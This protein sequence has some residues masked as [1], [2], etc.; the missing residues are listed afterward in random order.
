MAE[1]VMT[2][3][4]QESHGSTK[5]SVLSPILINI[6]VDFHTLYPEINILQ[7]A[8]DFC[9]YAFILLDKIRKLHNNS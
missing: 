7:F 1:I 4:D 6:T 8:D 3:Q 2:S 5:S 9:F